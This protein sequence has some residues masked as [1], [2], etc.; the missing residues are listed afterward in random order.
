ML[1]CAFSADILHVQC[2]LQRAAI[3]WRKPTT[4]DC[5]P[6]GR[7]LQDMTEM[8]ICYMFNGRNTRQIRTF[9]LFYVSSDLHA[10]MPQ[11]ITKPHIVH[12][13]DTNAREG[14]IGAHETIHY[15]QKNWNVQIEFEMQT[16]MFVVIVLYWRDFCSWI[17]S[18]TIDDVNLTMRY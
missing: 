14:S 4:I 5:L 8:V 15:N 11:W 3:E 9:V 16:T 1:C 2:C 13:F 17:H 7:S 18:L 12:R 6:F 10:L